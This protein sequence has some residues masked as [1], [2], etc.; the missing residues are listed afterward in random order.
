MQSSRPIHFLDDK[1]SPLKKEILWFD[2]LAFPKGNELRHPKYGYLGYRQ[3]FVIFFDMDVEIPKEE[4]VD[5]VIYSDDGF[6]LL[7]DNKKVMEYLKDRPFRKSERVVRLHPGKHHIR[8]K[9]FQGYGQ[10]GIVGYYSVGESAEE[11]KRAKKYLIG[12]NS[13]SMRFLEQ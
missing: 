2:T 5:F 4:Y 3:N 9:Y 6:R 12:K 1:V 11:A 8:I 7:I 13:P 10:L